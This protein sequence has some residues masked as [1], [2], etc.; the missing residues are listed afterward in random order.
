LKKVSER[1]EICDWEFATK[2][3]NSSQNFNQ[4]KLERELKTV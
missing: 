4:K 3:K 1:Q 2:R